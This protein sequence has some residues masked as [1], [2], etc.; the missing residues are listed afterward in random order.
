MVVLVKSI[1]KDWLYGK[2]NAKGEGMFPASFVDV[3]EAPVSGSNEAATS[4]EKNENRR[5]NSTVSEPSFVSG[6]RCRARFD[7]DGEEI[8]D[9]AFLAGET[10]RLLEQIGTEWF[11][12]ESA[13]GKIGMFPASFVEVLEELPAPVESPDSSVFYPQE[14]NVSSPGQCNSS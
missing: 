11:R 12:G 6:P 1:N 7:Y 8:G 9:L 14:E 2:K 4:V 5:N 3:V 13:G 10:I